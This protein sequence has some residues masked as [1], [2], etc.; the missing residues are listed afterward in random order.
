VK[1]EE[2]GKTIPLSGCR[3]NLMEPQKDSEAKE[4]GLPNTATNVVGW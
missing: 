4:K 3:E 2:E 1:E